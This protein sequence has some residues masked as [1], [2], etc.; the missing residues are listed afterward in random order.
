MTKPNL[1]RPSGNKYTGW[2]RLQS[3]EYT[4]E[5]VLSGI[6]NNIKFSVI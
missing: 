4:K 1:K 6:D 3:Y 5:S 2:S